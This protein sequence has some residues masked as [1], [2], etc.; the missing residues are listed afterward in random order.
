MN[1]NVYIRILFLLVF[2]IHE[3]VTME[4]KSEMTNEE[5]LSYLSYLPHELFGKI[6]LA[7]IPKRIQTPEKF[8]EV[9]TLINN[10]AGVCKKKHALFDED[11]YFKQIKRSLLGSIE[12]CAVILP[13]MFILRESKLSLRPEINTMVE[14]LI[15][16]A[17]PESENWQE[18]VSRLIDQGL[19]S[20]LVM[21]EYTDENSKSFKVTL[22]SR[23]LKTRKHDLALKLL[24]NYACG[25]DESIEYTILIDKNDYHGSHFFEFIKDAIQQGLTPNTYATMAKGGRAPLLLFAIRLTN[26]PITRFL[27]EQ[28]VDPEKKY[29]DM[30]VEMSPFE[31][32]R[33]QTC[34]CAEILELLQKYKKDS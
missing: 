2:A 20:N 13:F 4:H 24:N 10:F 6:I 8:I 17:S 11:Y 33:V 32:A 21:E 25:S 26:I 23:A 12:S 5:S 18:V 31:L 14:D 19:N 16:V 9:V 28:G 34:P 30:G 3:T 1:K 15:S 27:L 7:E 29:L 22:L